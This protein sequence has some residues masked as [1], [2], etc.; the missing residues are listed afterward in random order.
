ML[1]PDHGVSYL[2]E[3]NDRGKESHSIPMVW[4]GGAIKEAKEIKKYASQ[5]DMGST[6]LTQLG[7]DY[8]KFK[9][10]RNIADTTLTNFP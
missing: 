5:S 1:I 7:I 10:S 8:S 2:L 6:L 3:Y 9:Y 4:C